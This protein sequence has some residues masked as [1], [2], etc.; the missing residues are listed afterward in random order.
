MCDCVRACE[1]ASET[2]DACEWLSDYSACH[3]SVFLTDVLKNM[4][5][6]RPPPGGQIGKAMWIQRERIQQSLDMEDLGTR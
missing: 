2:P 4:K 5:N 6:E 1:R 3:Y